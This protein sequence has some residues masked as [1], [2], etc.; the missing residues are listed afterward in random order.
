MRWLR[1]LLLA[2]MALLTVAFD[3]TGFSGCAG[4]GPPT[5]RPLP[6]SSEEACFAASDCPPMACEDRRCISGRCVEFAPFRDG[7]EDGEAPIPCGMDCDDADSRVF[8]GAAEACNGRDDDCDGRTD[9]DAPPGVIA[10]PIGTAADTL[11][12]AAIGDRIV[13]T[14]SGFTAGLRLRTADFQGHIS[15]AT[16]VTDA[17]PSLTGLCS[18]GEGAVAVLV[19]EDATDFVIETFPLSLSGAGGLLVGAVAFSVHRAAEPVTLAVEPFGDSFA[20]AWDESGARFV[21]APTWPDPIQ[22]LDAATG[23]AP[24]D[25]ATDGTNLA[26][27][28]ASD[29]VAFFGPTGASIGTVTLPGRLAEEPLA[30]S[31]GDFVV[32]YRD[33]FDHVL[34][35]MTTTGAGMGHTAPAVG[36]GFPLRVDDTPL[37]V[38]V[39][40]FDTILDG[41]AG[42]SAQLLRPTLDTTIAT[43]RAADV[44]AGIMGAPV[45]FDVIA[46]GTG[47]AVITNFGGSGAVI[48][49]L[50]C[51]P[52]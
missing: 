4:S 16:S 7:D 46:S 22:V 20:L 2:A 28:S 30:S 32:G 17:T 49:V 33:T 39:T 11:A 18:V 27:P 29:G 9:E 21:M 43:F 50:G 8:P 37:G 34:A 25:L 19:R 35:R 14:D 38:L 10:T 6:V 26:V 23:V 52:L 41:E 15:S 40:R 12:A 24:L 42:V 51:Q 44:S 13:L 48:S 1:L 3:G 36:A 47:T 5:G 31:T 45:S